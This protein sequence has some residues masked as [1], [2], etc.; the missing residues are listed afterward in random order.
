MAILLR[1]GSRISA[2]AGGTGNGGNIRISSPIIVGIGNS[3]IIA[4]AVRGR[5]GNIQLT[6]Q[7]LL[8]LKYR[9]ALTPA[10]DITAS[11]EFGLN[12]N[13]QVN[14]IGINPA[15]SLNALPTNIT[16]SS[17]QIADRCGNT[18]TSSFIATGRGG[19]PQGP[20]KRG[21]D[22]PWHDLRPLTAANPVV[23]SIAITNSV[24]PL[25]EASSIQIDKTGLIS[26]VAAKPIGL[27][28]AATCGMGESH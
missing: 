15:N 24:E 8:S 21:S 19:I 16:D 28:A 13:V 1:R 12:G 27:L 7:A 25:I 11:S 22:R 5:G 6:T 20:K 14:T 10:N 3:D 2:E 4:T 9:P 18:Q 23:T 17:T 26:L